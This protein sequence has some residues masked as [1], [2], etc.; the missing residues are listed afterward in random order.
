MTA[1]VAE[2]LSTARTALEEIV[3]RLATLVRSIRDPDRRALGE[4]TVGDLVLHLAQVWEVVP[5]LA[6]RRL[7]SFLA[8]IWELGTVTTARV[9]AEAERDVG[10][11]ADRIEAAAGEFLAATAGGGG[12]RMRPWLV[13][14]VGLP[15]SC[16]AC[17]LLNECLVHGY[18]IARADGA[19][20]HVDPFHARLV[21]LGF[22][23]PVLR[24]LPADALVD[25]RRAAGLRAC[26]DVRLRGGGQ[27]YFVF[28]DGALS[29]EE[30][31][32]RRVDCHVF[33]DPVD[34]LLVGW[35]RKGQWASIARG[36]LLAWGRR[37]WLGVRLKDLI[38][39]P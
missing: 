2:D 22:L 30:P 4:W 11:L 1:I 3:P 14:G 39:N 33:A 36:R 19:Q 15:L 20:W 23:L 28:H 10:A 25:Q 38:R 5:G 6:T 31:S 32:S 27:A 16:F 37:P 35:G 13:E 21:I 8:D 12:D 17:H 7:H 29:L 9:R 24:A 34:L 18:D 26:Y